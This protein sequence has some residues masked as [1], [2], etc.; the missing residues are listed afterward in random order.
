MEGCVQIDGMAA[1][2]TGGA[3]GLGGATAMA[4]AEA[5]AKVAILDVNA[6]AAEQAASRIGGLG[7]ACDVRDGPAME[8]ALA[9]ASKAH[10][11]A[12]ILVNCAGIGTPGRAVGRDGPLALEKFESVIAV[13]LTGTFNAARLAAFGMQSLDPL[14]EGERGVIINT[15]SVAAYEGQVGQPAYAASKGGIVALTLPLA[16]EFAQFGIRVMTIAPGIFETPMLAGLPEEVRE[17]LAADVPFPRRL[18]Q[19]EDYARLALHIVES[20]MMNGETIRLDGAIR[21]KPR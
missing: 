6:A 10:G 2:V 16:R 11:A 13:N 3:S 14:A 21:L 19:P 17:T 15:A 4:L 1:I 9:A 18:G 12:R 20:P 7:L 8:A 5:G